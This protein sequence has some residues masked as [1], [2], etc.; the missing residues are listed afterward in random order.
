MTKFA[1]GLL[2]GLLLGATLAV[3]VPRA[4]RMRKVAPVAEDIARTI[5]Q[6]PRFAR[7]RVTAKCQALGFPFG[8][9]A[10]WDD[11]R[12]IYVSGSVKTHRDYEDLAVLLY[13]WEDVPVDFSFLIG[14]P[15]VASD[16]TGDSTTT[17]SS[18]PRQAA[19]P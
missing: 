17:T 6:D 18:A 2:L 19:V 15:S 5:A 7:V 12:F 4:A 3:V 14:M 1:C 9:R 11:G 8:R 10:W 16:G 13:N